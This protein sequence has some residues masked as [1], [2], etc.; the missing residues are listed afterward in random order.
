MILCLFFVLSVILCAGIAKIG[1][2]FVFVAVDVVLK[3]VLKINTSH[4][5]F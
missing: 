1:G 3:T 5:D 4:K 2:N